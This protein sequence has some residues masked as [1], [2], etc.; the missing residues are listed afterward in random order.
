MSVIAN[1][2]STLM[3]IPLTLNQQNTL[4]NFLELMG[5]QILLIQAQGSL[6]APQNINQ[7]QINEILKNINFKFEYIEEVIIYLKEAFFKNNRQ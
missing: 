1:I 5:Q 4:G 6:L 7:T 2:I 3:A